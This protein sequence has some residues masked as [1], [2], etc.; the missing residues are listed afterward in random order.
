MK[1]CFLRKNK[2][3]VIA[4]HARV[5]EDGLAAPK[6]EADLK[7][8]GC[9]VCNHLAK[10]AFEFFWKFQDD[11][12]TNQATQQDFADNLGFCPLHLW[13]LE[14]LLSSLGMSTGFAALVEHIS[15][16]LS[17]RAELPADGQAPLNLICNSTDCRVCQLLHEEQQKYVRQLTS[18]VEGANERSTYA[19][20]QGVCLRH[21][22]V[23]LAVPPKEDV[24][25]FLLKEAARRFDQIREDMRNFS[26]KNDALPRPLVNAD[27][28]DAHFRALV[29]IAG[30]KA[31]CCSWN[32]HV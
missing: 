26:L 15:R 29:H 7:T 23:W 30:S 6:L 14:P 8:R 18:F 1:E 19:C 21:L 17:A 28:R 27:E 25:R 32:T 31:L 16:M 12:A 11:F 3:A 4:R 2:R 22:G 9:P 13:Q 10:A 20:S 5:P 24:S